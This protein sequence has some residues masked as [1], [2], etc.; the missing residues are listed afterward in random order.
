MA[1]CERLRVL[2]IP[3]VVRLVGFSGHPSVLPD[4]EM[5]ALRTSVAKRLGVEPHPYLSVG[6]RV[7][8][9]SGPLAGVDGILVRKKNVLRVILSIDFIL[10]SAAV[11]VDA[12]DIERIG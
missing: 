1:L 7:R 9:K 6:H 10:C 5:D 3:S 11:E 2:Q 8:I 12:S 4:R